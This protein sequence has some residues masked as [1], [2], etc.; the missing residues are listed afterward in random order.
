MKIKIFWIPL[1]K[2]HNLDLKK[3]LIQA[4]KMGYSRILIESGATLAGSF[5]NNNLVDDFKLFISNKNLKKHGRGEVKNLLKLLLKNK[6]IIKEKVNLFGD[7]LL[8][9]KMK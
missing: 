9:Y 7:K 8:S 2:N 4:K 3:T 1:N 5:L 6:K